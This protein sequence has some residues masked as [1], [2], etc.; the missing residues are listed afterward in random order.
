MKNDIT[1]LVVDL[2]DGQRIAIKIDGVTLGLSA[3]SRTMEAICERFPEF[4]EI[5]VA[6]V[7]II[8]AAEYL[9][10]HGKLA[11]PMMPTFSMC[12]EQIHEHLW[13]A[14]EN[15]YSGGIY[16]KEGDDYEPY[17]D[18]F[19]SVALNGLLEEREPTQITIR[20]IQN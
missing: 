2:K 14:Y 7:V 11:D 8:G 16:I 12:V 10:I 19:Y 3:Q 15:D 6:M 4:S 17:L 1:N 18:D 20:A 9:K 13:E 5:Q